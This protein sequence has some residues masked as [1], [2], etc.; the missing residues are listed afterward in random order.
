MR[1]LDLP[2]AQSVA[3]FLI[4]KPSLQSLASAELD[5]TELARRQEA[6][7]MVDGGHGDLQ[8][9][10]YLDEDLL[11]GVA[12]SSAERL[13]RDHLTA[14]CLVAEGLSHF[15]YAQFRATQ[16]SVFSELELELQGEVDKYALALECLPPEH[17]E[18]SAP[19]LRHC[20]FKRARL[21]DPPG[22]D[23][24]HRYRRAH[25]LAESYLLRLERRLEAVPCSR[26][27]S[28]RR[29]NLRRYHRLG[30]AGKSQRGEQ[31][32][33]AMVGRLSALSLC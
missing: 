9:G 31:A 10:L 15:H 17:R 4:G 3:A 25:R 18:A 23:A 29:R 5:L 20:L 30:L 22:S 19:A 21:C 14:F 27:H 16:L 24:W 12:N 11:A 32:R 8:L 1:L 28:E 33:V 7:I 2:K 13:A 6:L 26:R